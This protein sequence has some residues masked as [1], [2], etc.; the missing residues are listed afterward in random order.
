MKKLKF[1]LS[2]NLFDAANNAIREKS[3]VIGL[4][5]NTIPE[6]LI[7]E[8]VDKNLGYCEVIIDKMS[9]IVYTLQKDEKIYKK[10]SFSFPF[11]LKENTEEGISK[12]LIS[13]NNGLYLD[14]QII[15]I[16]LILLHEGLFNENIN[17]DIEPLEFYDRIYQAI[18][19]IEADIYITETL[20]WHFIRKLFLFEPGYVRYDYDDDITRCDEIT[21]P[22][23]HLDFYFSGN[24]TMKL[25]VAKNNQDF[26]KWKEDSF[27][28]LLNIKT[29][30][31]Y[32]KI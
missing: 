25:G 1:Y 27:E 17:S 10:F 29:P 20:I 18:N 21:H 22:L 13:D 26:V 32:L 14:S 30:C 11:H 2:H 12:W 6:L 8:S 28:N 3:D 4:L 19:E 24:A 23:H 15:T 7:D 9:R 5:L 31:Y 16:L